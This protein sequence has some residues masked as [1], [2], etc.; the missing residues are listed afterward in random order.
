M[1][2][3]QAVS[4]ATAAVLALAACGSS[5][6]GA[7]S[8]SQLES[9]LKKD[10]QLSQQLKAAHLTQKQVSVALKCVAKALRKDADPGDLNDYV[11]G[12]KNLTDVGG[13]AKGSAQK[14]TTDAETCVRDAL[15]G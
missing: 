5:G 8:Q 6:G 10:T 7:P 3:R 9:K 15:G 11:D 12:K 13:K 2:R 4:A 1:L 14:L